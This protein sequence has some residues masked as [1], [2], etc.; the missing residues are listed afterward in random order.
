MYTNKKLHI[1]L[2]IHVCTQ[3][4]PYL[5]NFQ[6]KCALKIFLIRPVWFRNVAIEAFSMTKTMRT[7]R[8]MAMSANSSESLVTVPSI[9]SVLEYCYRKLPL[10]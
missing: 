8:M 10:R 9:F 7:V 3:T 4:N 1:H 2:K 5:D 6:P